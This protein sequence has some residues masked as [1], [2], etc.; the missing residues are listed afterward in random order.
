[1]SIQSGLAMTSQ[2][3]G[4]YRILEKIGA[5][6]MGEVFR[7]RDERLGRDVALKFVNP[8][9]A[10]DPDRLRRFDKE[11]RAAAALN[12]PNIVAIYDSGVQDDA[13]YIVSELLQGQTLRERLCAGPLNVRQ[14]AEYGFQISEALV[15][16]HEK[17]IIHRDL[18][19]ENIFITRENRIKILDFGIAK[20]LPDRENKEHSLGTMETQTRMGSVLGT[21]AYMA[22]EQLRCKEVD[23]RSDIFSVGAILYEML[24]GKR[25]FHGETDVDTITA[26]LKEDPPEMMAER[27]QIPPAFEQIVSHCLEKDPE[28]RFQ[29]ARDLS[30]SLSTLAGASGTHDFVMPGPSLRLR[31]IALAVL[32]AGALAAAVWF[33]AALVLKPAAG[34][35][36]QRITFQRGTVFGARFTSDGRI[37]YEA[38]WN[39]RDPKLFTTLNNPGQTH[40]LDLAD[41]HLLAVSPNNELALQVNGR[42]GAF[43]DYV[44]GTLA[45][46]P[47]AGGSP[48][49]LLSDVHWA[50]WNSTGQL[51]VIHEVKGH[52]QLEFPIGQVLYRSSGWISHLRFSP[53]GE[54]LAFMDHPAV[55]DDRGVVT[56]SDLDGQTTPLTP[57]YSS[58]YGLA[59]SPSGEIWYTAA[60]AG[61]ERKLMAVSLSGRVREVLTG[62]TTLDLQDIAPDGRALMSSEQPRVILEFLGPKDSEPRDLSWYDNSIIKEISRDGQ[63]IL[64]EEFS[65]PFGSDY[66]VA[67][68]KVDGSPPIHLGAGSAGGLSPDGK[69]ALDVAVGKNPRVSHLPIGPGQ[70]RIVPTVGLEH[71]QNGSARFLPDGTHIVLNGNEPG[72]GVRGYRLDL[73]GGKPIP[74]MPEGMEAQVPS[75]DSRWIVAQTPDSPVVLCSLETGETRPIPGV[76]REDN[77]AEWTSDSSGL[78]VYRQYQRP[79]RIEKIDLRTGTRVLVREVYPSERFGVISVDPI[80]MTRDA[81]EIAFSYYQNLTSLY[82]VE[83]LR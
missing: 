7:A 16:A 13:P 44:G 79:V 69:W 77:V 33:L 26:V 70:P 30:F 28:R 43:L 35:R 81:S 71:V 9:C 3:V 24:T 83:G 29:S 39:N 55:W 56:V 61:T 54:K 48:R 22:P 68:R 15:A 46:A 14:A 20:L 8:A 63:W 73:A 66:A 19:P 47:I 82:I 4:H 6:G 23:G 17:N 76:H 62:A 52:S 65:E 72:H 58:E 45:Q 75:P 78:Y 25:A 40:A 51:A 18:K 59:W 42:H 21:V 57:E 50:D 31:R 10:S 74:I 2:V 53:N 80:A 1:M 11:A 60:P 38:A 41:A 64:F 37:V 34:A 36:Y 12:H 32:G 49:E 5:G 67:A 27:G